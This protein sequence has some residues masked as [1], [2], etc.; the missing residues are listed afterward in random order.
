MSSA[1]NQETVF[2]NEKN[3]HVTNARLV[4][5]AQTYAMSG[6]TSV[7]TG[8]DQPSK[9]IPIILIIIGV[10]ALT[11]GMKGF[12]IGAI[13]I[14]IGG[15]WIYM[16]KNTYHMFLH[17]ASGKTQALSSYDESWI[18]QVVKAVNEAIIHRG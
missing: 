10:L 2:L 5:P 16:M 11:A 7:E 13:F 14:A 6:I 3:I 9:L 1:A 8:Y 15:A 4:L 12:F 17:T 18:K